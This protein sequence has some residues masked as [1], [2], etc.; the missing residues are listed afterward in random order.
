MQ[1][2][3]DSTDS[4]KT[5]AGLLSEARCDAL[6]DAIA[7]GRLSVQQCLHQWDEQ[8]TLEASSRWVEVGRT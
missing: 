3:C 2:L 7:D 8:G 5:L 4:L 6:T 1:P